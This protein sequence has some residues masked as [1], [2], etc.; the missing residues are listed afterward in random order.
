MKFT[1][2]KVSAKHKL[3]SEK[4]LKG[5]AKIV[6]P[7]VPVPEYETFEEFVHASGTPETALDFINTAVGKEAAVSV[8]EFVTDSPTTGITESQIVERAIEYGKSFTPST[9]TS[10]KEK[11]SIL[12]QI[13]ARVRTEG[14]AAVQDDLLALAQRMS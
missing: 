8:R 9:K 5:N 13:L 10:S 3:G 1:T 12:D 6:I 14:A 7:E 4:D 11:G 2:K